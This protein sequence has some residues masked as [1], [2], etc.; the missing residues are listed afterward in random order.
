M[1]EYEY[2]DSNH[3]FDYLEYIIFKAEIS[4]IQDF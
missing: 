4:Y 1:Q 2:S 3:L